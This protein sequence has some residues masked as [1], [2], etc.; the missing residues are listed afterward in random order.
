LS[1]LHALRAVY[2]HAQDCLLP[3]QAYHRLRQLSTSV[4]DAVSYYLECH[5]DREGRVDLL[6]CVPRDR[7]ESLFERSRETEAEPSVLRLLRRWSE[8]SIIRNRI[9]RLWLSFDMVNPEPTPP[10]P[11]IL[12]CIDVGRKKPSRSEYAE[13]A[14]ELLGCF[15]L[16]STV[17]D[18]MLRAYD[19]LPVEGRILHISIMA[20]RV[21]VAVKLNCKM[22][23][24][25][26]GRFFSQL[27]MK[28]SI[29]VDLAGRNAPDAIVKFQISARP[30]AWDQIE[31]EYNY[32][33]PLLENPSRLRLLEGLVNDGL[34]TDR[35]RNGLLSWPG[36]DKSQF[37]GYKRRVSIR[38]WLDVKLIAGNRAPLPKAY[39]GFA[40]ILG[41]GS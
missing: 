22:E 11:G 28:D 4:T 33:D 24:G 5:L 8:P 21:P 31:I 6:A 19:A 23:S 13:T 17:L 14:D 12:A 2:Q 38:R 1:Y 15:G 41:L 3:L 40:P 36:Q 39:L 37:P 34:M 10:S 26:S 29:L 25:L 7:A 35:V 32:N 9:P 27:G 18:P 16:R 30:P 20:G